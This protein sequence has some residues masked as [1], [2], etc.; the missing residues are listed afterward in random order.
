MRI[1]GTFW[2]LHAK[3]ENVMGQNEAYLIAELL[4]VHRGSAAD[5]S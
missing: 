2:K 4:L 1:P 3:L 5:A